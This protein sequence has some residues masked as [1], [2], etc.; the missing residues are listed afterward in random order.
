MASSIKGLRELERKLKAIPKAT[1]NEVRS[2][3]VKSA[4][5]MVDLAQAIVPVDQGELKGTIRQHPGKNELA[6][7]VRAGGEATTVNGYDMAL[8]IEHGTSEVPEQPFFWNS[9]R[10]IKKKA[11]ARATRAIRKAARA[12]AG[13]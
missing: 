6:V 10:A 8:A 11:K 12:A 5:E 7:V 13:V 1:R 4:A 9:Y 3:L 2:V